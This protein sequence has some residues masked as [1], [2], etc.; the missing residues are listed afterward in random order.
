MSWRVVPIA[1]QHISSF[2]AGVDTVA[3]EHLY[4]SFLEAPPLE[5][6][7]AFVRS[8]I[9]GGF[10][11]FV[12]VA[13]QAVVGWCD[14]IPMPRPVHSHSGVLGMGVLPQWRRQGIG[15]NLLTHALTA[16]R[17]YGLTRVELTVRASNTVAIALYRSNGFELEGAKRKGVRIDGKYEDLICMAVIYDDAA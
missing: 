7:A 12:A 6:T 2:H 1:E 10:P 9:K 13:E 14:V 11:V 16:S 4:L 8:N 15:R 3:R 17:R 5:E